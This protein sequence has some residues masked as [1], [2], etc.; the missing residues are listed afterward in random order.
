MLIK[1]RTLIYPLTILLALGAMAC[2]QRI[3]DNPAFQAQTAEIEQLREDIDTLERRQATFDT[4]DTDL[5]QVTRDVQQ[6]LKGGGANPA[7]LKAFGTR[8]AQLEKTANASKTQNA[9]LQKQ[10]KEL[11]DKNKQLA[12]QVKKS[13]TRATSKNES[14]PSAS[15]SKS[16]SKSPATT[17]K[18][19]AVG[20]YHTVAQG[21]TI[22]DLAKRFGVSAAKLRA[23]NRLG[24]GQDAIAGAQIYIPAK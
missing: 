24:E 12:A 18:P 9:N 5:Q 11:T 15:A 19:K 17:E 7:A 21:E 13:A 10:V 20:H 23:E 2:T 14:A 3:E 8:I 1:N 6:L 22:A 4:L 16:T